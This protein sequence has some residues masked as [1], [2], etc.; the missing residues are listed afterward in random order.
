MIAM[1]QRDGNSIIVVIASRVLLPPSANLF[2]FQSIPQPTDPTAHPCPQRHA[3]AL[4]LHITQNRIIKR[5]LRNTRI[6][7]IAET[8]THT[9]RAFATGLLISRTELLELG[10]V[11][12]TQC[13]GAVIWLGV[14]IAVLIAGAVSVGR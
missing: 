9:G 2:S 11:A 13:S 12:W 3:H 10:S 6:V 1:Q 14:T 5:T 8:A 4:M 7:Q